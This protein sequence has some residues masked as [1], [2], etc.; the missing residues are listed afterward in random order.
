ME[1]ELQVLVDG[2]STGEQKGILVKGLGDVFKG[3]Y[4][5]E[6]TSEIVRGKRPNLSAFV[7]NLQF[8]N[9]NVKSWAPVQFAFK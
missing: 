8:Y 9:K 5:N 2:L 7:T 1:A 6:K 3:T 4:F